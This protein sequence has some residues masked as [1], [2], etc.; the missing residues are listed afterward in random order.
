MLTLPCCQRIAVL[1]P[2]RTPKPAA[3]TAQKIPAGSII[4]CTAELEQVE[5]RKVWMR[6]RVTDGKGS[7]YA[8]ARALFVA[9]RMPGERLADAVKGWLGGGRGA[10]AASGQS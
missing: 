6:A 10:A 7:T 3:R 5:G 8:C 2:T 9:P 4:Q 1:A